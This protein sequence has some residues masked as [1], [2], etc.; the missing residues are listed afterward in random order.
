MDSSVLKQY[1]EAVDQ[2]RQQ[3]A[4]ML[5]LEK[6]KRQALLKNEGK[7][8]E[9]VLK[10]QQAALMQLE[11]LEKKRLQAHKALGF[12]EQDTAA[13]VVASLPDGPDKQKLDELIHALKE[14]ADELREQNK[15]SL[16]L[17]RLDLKLAENLRAQAGEP[18]DAGLYG[19]SHGTGR[20]TGGND[21]SDCF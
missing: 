7:R 15:E 2:C 10:D 5:T 20:P 17:A 9:S 8:I 16:E 3:C 21:F 14:C 18:T 11:A 1:I 4:Q 19:P 13:Q 6:E 12:S